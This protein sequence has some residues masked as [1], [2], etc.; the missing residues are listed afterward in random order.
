MSDNEKDNFDGDD[1]V[2]DDEY[3][4]EDDVEV[5]SGDEEDQDGDAA[6]DMNQRGTKRVAKEER[7]TGKFMTKYER[8]RILGARAL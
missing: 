3:G 1:G 8:A 2:D 7:I 4:S 5:L 6:E